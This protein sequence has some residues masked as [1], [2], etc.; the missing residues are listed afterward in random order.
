MFGQLELG[1]R[2]RMDT[3]S[4]PCR[5]LAGYVH[6]QWMTGL[7][8]TF[9]FVDMVMVCPTVFRADEVA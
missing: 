8:I 6:E 4:S 1:G 3:S 7:Y 2:Y 9:S 5:R